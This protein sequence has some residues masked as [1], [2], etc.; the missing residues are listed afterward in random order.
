MLSRFLTVRSA[1]LQTKGKSPKM[2]LPFV[3]NDISSIYFR[4]YTEFEAVS[5]S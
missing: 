1:G 4:L 3:T 5:F 2:D